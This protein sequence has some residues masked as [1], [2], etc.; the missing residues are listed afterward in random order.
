VTDG[1]TLTPAIS[2]GERGSRAPVPESLAARGLVRATDNL[3][4]GAR[5]SLDSFQFVICFRRELERVGFPIK[6]PEQGAT[7]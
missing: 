4:P 7:K 1:L 3:A 6:R 2:Q 5:V